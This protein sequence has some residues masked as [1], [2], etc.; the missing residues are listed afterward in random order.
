LRIDLKHSVLTPARRLSLRRATADDIRLIADLHVQSWVASYRGMLPDTY[1]DHDIHEERAAHWQ[2]QRAGLEA[3]TL[4]VLIAQLDDT[5]IGFVCM[6][7]PDQHGR[8]LIDNLHALPGHKGAGAGTAM[9]AAAQQWAREHRAGGMYLE[10]LE[11]NLPA[12]GFYESR[13]W[14]REARE[15]EQMAGIDITVLRY[16]FPLD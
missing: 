4:R 15:I 16:I 6:V 10:V 5:P 11:A 9:L 8:V 2:A 1:L 12:I 3:G 14:Q 7:R 13:G